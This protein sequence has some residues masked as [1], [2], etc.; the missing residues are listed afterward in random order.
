MCEID[1]CDNNLRSD[2]LNLNDQLKANNEI[3][4]IY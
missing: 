3:I 4:S 2:N 1:L